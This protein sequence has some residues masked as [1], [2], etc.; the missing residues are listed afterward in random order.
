MITTILFD[1]DGTLLP[2]DQDVFLK[3]YM[4]GLAKKGAAHGYDPETLVRNIW[5]CTESMIKNDGT[6][7]NETVFWDTFS[8]LCGRDTRQDMAVFD[9]FY[10]N[11]FQQVQTSCGFDPRAAEAI[12]SIKKMGF[13]VALATNPL[14]PAIATYSRC[15][16][17]GL[18]PA[19]F[20]LI[21]TY[22]NSRHCKPNRD[23]YA[24][25]LQALG[26]SPQE[27]VMVG[28]DALEDMVAET[29]G[30]RV[31]LLTDCLLNKNGSDIRPYP[32]GSF[33][34]LLDYIQKL[35]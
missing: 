5:A 2:M 14:F 20:D 30:I 33:P 19:D 28:N 17:A 4:S 22:E 11:E 35:K 25:V 24:D 9:D 21:T 29:L 1:L 32:Q 6:A 3:A 34:E 26:V 15:R 31:F 13:R 7:T 16:W 23:Y 27:C 10:R 12:R 18:D 8:A